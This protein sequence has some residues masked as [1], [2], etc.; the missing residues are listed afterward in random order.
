MPNFSDKVCLHI[1][2]IEGVSL[3]AFAFHPYIRPNQSIHYIHNPQA[4]G[5]V[6]LPH[7]EVILNMVDMALPRIVEGSCLRVFALLAP[8]YHYW[9][10]HF[11]TDP[12][13]LHP[14]RNQQGHKVFLQQ[15][16][17]L[18]EKNQILTTN[19]WWVFAFFG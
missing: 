3:C 6:L 2:H 7:L 4:V 12:K 15:I 19:I 13:G 5:K 17:G 9:R 10:N 1:V 8:S 14:L 11:P 16:V 18:D